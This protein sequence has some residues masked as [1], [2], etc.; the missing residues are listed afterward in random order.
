MT[1]PNRDRLTVIPDET[2]V[3]FLIGMR[4]NRWWLV[5]VWWGVAMAM[6]RMLRQLAADPD[7]GLLHE[8]S[9]LGRTTISVQYWRSLDHLQAYAHAR[10][11]AHAAVWKQWARSWGLGGAVG[12]WH[13]TY[14]I[15][16]GRTE[17]VY[18]HMPPFGLGAA[19]GLVPA[20]DD[21]A[22]ATQR[23]GR[24]ERAA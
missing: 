19:G 12:I 23:M 15:E 7:M 2:F 10:D 1:A 6:Q 14:V 20:T 22:T 5:P 11:K 4:V 13:E 17:N 8:E 18:V 16:P 21:L 24:P 3:V 9:W